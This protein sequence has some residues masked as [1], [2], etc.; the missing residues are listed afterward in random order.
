M[1]GWL[2]PKYPEVDAETFILW[3][4]CSKSHGEIVPGYTSY[5]LSLGYKVLVLM[6]PE[7]I[8]EGVFSR[9][10]H[11]RLILGDL[12]QRQIRK[13]MKTEA[14]HKAAGVLITTAGKLPRLENASPDLNAVFDS[15]VPPKL[16]L[17]EHDAVQLFEHGSWRPDYITLRALEEPSCVVNPHDFGKTQKTPKSEGKTIFTMVGAAR[18]KRRNDDIVLNAAERLVAEGITNFE[19]RLIGKKGALT[20]PE[21]LTAHVTEVGRVDFE[22]LY[23]EVER[24]DFVLTAFQGDNPDHAFYRTTGTTGSFQLAYGFHKPCILQQ[25][26]AVGTA[27]NN[28]NSLFYDA[29]EGMYDALRRAITMSAADY[30]VMQDAMRDSANALSASSLANLKALIHD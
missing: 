15:R 8:S 4:P 17:V 14:V 27:L 9:M 2:R 16:F 28:E 6:T 29:D 20:I 24:G 26:F 19:I 22:E 30:A 25:N 11:P 21:S 23:S 12:P 5:L 1:F 10:Q 18:S 3:E 13:F 7:R